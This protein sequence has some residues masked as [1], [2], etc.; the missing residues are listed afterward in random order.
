MA[1][2]L[3][4]PENIAAAVETARLPENYQRAKLALAEC[5]AV[6]QCLDWAD[7][8]AALATYARQAEDAELENY[9]R[10]IRLRAVRRVGELLRAIAPGKP[11]PKSVG[12][13]HRSPAVAPQ[14]LLAYHAIKKTW[15]SAS[16][17]YPRPNLRRPLR[18]T[19]RRGRKGFCQNAE[20]SPSL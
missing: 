17:A 1:H 5:E 2:D 3:V 19:T 12:A 9:A 7:R 15:R 14:R 8:A 20:Q 6:D 18:A 10:R 4:V 13:P 16:P 11:G